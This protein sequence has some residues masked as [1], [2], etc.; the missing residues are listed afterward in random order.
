MAIAKG[1]HLI[2]LTPCSRIKG[3]R[4]PPATKQK[5][6]WRLPVAIICSN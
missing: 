4:H 6:K 1:N 5:K 3:L 2:H